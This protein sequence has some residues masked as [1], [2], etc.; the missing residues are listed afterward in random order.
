[1]SKYPN[2]NDKNFY[3]KINTIYKKY[4]VPKK[5]TSLESFCMPKQYT[6]QLPQQFLAE[7][8]SDSTPYNGILVYHRIGAGKT[9]TAIRIGEKWKGK[10]K[11]IVVL[12]ASLKG[13]FRNELRTQCAGDNYL[14]SKERKKLS[15]LFFPH[16]AR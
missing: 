2:I 10:K 1:M 4:K 7:F 3:K 5:K 15:E 13:N 6:L 16:K 8:M 12:P 9:C 14:T 11:I